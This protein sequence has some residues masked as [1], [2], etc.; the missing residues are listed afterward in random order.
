VSIVDAHHHLW[1]RARRDCPWMT[2]EGSALR[3]RYGLGGLRAVAGA[4]CVQATVLVQA[5]TAE[6]ETRE[7]LALAD[8]SDGLVRAVVGRVDLTAPD[9]ADRLGAPREAGGHLLAGIRHPVED[10]RDPDHAEV[11]EL[12]EDVLDGLGPD[13]RASVLAGTAQRLYGVA[14]VAAEG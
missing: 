7:L 5:A 14:V 8:G 2:G 4:A 10:E 9:V 13:E 12:A 3:R 1:D 11:L 6:E